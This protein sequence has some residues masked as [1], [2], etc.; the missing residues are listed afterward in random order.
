M[1]ALGVG[2]GIL[3]VGQKDKPDISEGN[4]LIAEKMVN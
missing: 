4:K 2:S 1:K 3:N